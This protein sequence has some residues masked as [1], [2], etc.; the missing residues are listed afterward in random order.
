MSAKILQ[1]VEDDADT[2]LNLI[3]SSFGLK[4]FFLYNFPAFLQLRK[5]MVMEENLPNIFV[6]IFEKS[7]QICVFT[8]WRK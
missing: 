4:Y 6:A 1:L 3:D 5:P 2:E 8:L 7:Q